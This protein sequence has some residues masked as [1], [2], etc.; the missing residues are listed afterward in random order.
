M[1][2]IQERWVGGQ[3]RDVERA[4]GDGEAQLEK[5]RTS[6]DKAKTDVGRDAEFRITEVEPDLQHKLLELIDQCA[7]PV[8]RSDDWNP[9][10][11][12]GGNFDDAYELGR[13]DGEA[14]LAQMIREPF[15]D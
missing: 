11:G 15:H 6:F 9:L 7:K 4:K 2:M 13:R 3:W 1:K 12:S 10:D 14:D 8:E 5:L